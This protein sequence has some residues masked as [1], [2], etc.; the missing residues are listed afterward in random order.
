[1]LS[2]KIG[3]CSGQRVRAAVLHR[4]SRGGA[5]IPIRRLHN[6]SHPLT[7]YKRIPMSKIIDPPHNIFGALIKSG[8]IQNYGA[9][10]K[11]PRRVAAALRQ[12]AKARKLKREAKER[13]APIDAPQCR[14]RPGSKPIG[15]RMYDQVVRRMVPGHWYSRGDLASAA[16]FGL[17]SRGS[18]MRSLLAGALATRA[19]N[20]QADIG[21]STRPAPQWLYRLTAK[22][23]ALRELC[24][25]LS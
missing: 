6:T 25:L 21:T 10:Q 19:R 18:L 1:M 9:R 12:H 15:T 4:F 13:S 17:D 23:E 22:G 3:L 7:K 16:G 8:L 20:P 14:R 5:S 2:G 24:R 11:N